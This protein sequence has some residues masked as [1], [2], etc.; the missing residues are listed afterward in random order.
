M[1]RGLAGLI[2]LHRWRLDEKRE[3]VAELERLAARLR[4]ELSDLDR[5]FADHQNLAVAP[6][7]GTSIDDH[8]AAVAI[9]RRAKLTASLMEVE[10]RIRGALN[11]VAHAAREIEKFDLVKARRE[12]ALKER[13]RH[14]EPAGVDSLGPPVERHRE[15]A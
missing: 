12:R 2:R 11:E 5:H 4:H 8:P 6:P 3:T 13:E 1:T 9:A 15:K 10:G 7:A 14:R